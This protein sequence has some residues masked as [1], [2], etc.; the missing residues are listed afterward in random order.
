MNKLKIFLISLFSLIGYSN[1]I[2]QT[3]D[4][5]AGEVDFYVPGILANDAMQQVNFLLCFIENTNFQTFVDR[6]VYKA[7][8]DEAKCQSADGA[9]ANADQAAATGSSASTAGTGTAGNQVD[10][11]NYTPAVFQNVTEGNTLSGKG[12]VSLNFEFAEGAPPSAVTAYVKT[13]VSADASATNRF[14]T[15]LMR[16]DLRNDSQINLGGGANLP[17]NSEI[18]KGYLDVDNT[19]IKYRMQGFESPPRALD[20]DLADLNNIQ[21]ILQSTVRVSASGNLTTY[22][23]IHQINVNEGANRY[24]Q[25]FLSANQWSQVGTSWTEG[26]AITEAN[27]AAAISGADYVDTDGGIGATTTGQHCWDLRKSQAK[28]VVYE[29]GTY[30]ASNNNRLSLATPSMSLEANTTDNGGLSSPIWAFASYWGVHVN[31]NRRGDVTDSIQF[32]NQR[33][34]DD[35]AIYN[36]RKNYYEITKRERQYLSLNQLGGVSFQM[37]V[38]WQKNDATWGPKMGNLNF[39]NTGACNAAQGNCPEYSGTITVEG[40]TVTFTVTHGMNW[41]AGITP[42]E[43]NNSFSFTAAMWHTQMTN[44]SGWTLDMDFWDPDAHQSYSIP[45]AAFDAVASTNP[46]SQVRTRIESKI[47]LADLETDI[48]NGGAGATGLMCITRCL[49]VTNMNTS[50]AAAFTALGNGTSPSNALTTPFKDVGPWFKVATYYDSNN[51]NSVDNGETLYA[52]GSYNNIGGIRDNEAATYTVITEGGVKKLRDVGRNAVLEYSNANDTAL[53][54]RRHGDGLGNYRYKEKVS[55]YTVDNYEQNFGWAFN[56]QVVIDSNANKTA[57][58]CENESGEARGYNARYK[59][60]SGNAAQH[61]NAASGRTYYCESKLW[62]GAVATTYSIAIKQMPDYRLY[63]D[64]TSQFVN[65]SAPETVV[66]TVDANNVV[67]NFPNTNLAGKKYKLKFE[68][69]GELHNFP[70]RV[71]NTCTGTVVGRYV[72]NW[73]QCYRYV[74]EF[75]IKDGTVLAHTNNSRPDIKVRALRGDEYLLKLNPTPSGI[76]YTKQPSDLPAA[77]V[78]QTIFGTGT[79]GIGTVPTITIPSN[80]SNEAAVVHGVTVHSP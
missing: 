30:N 58:L 6:G 57:L 70:G 18:E 33:D 75:T 29:Y 43:L 72:N 71:V 5:D 28:R 1:L 44:G 74:H 45:Y 50:L 37:W 31:P 39:P 11:A 48:A 59:A 47:S 10:Q 46:A 16:Y 8:I 60:Q 77:S 53:S 80:G 22:S 40:S 51:N 41:S 12:W 56:M 13:T 34:K 64:T 66:L 67:Y 78:L 38:D 32:R 68:G 19:S 54:S 17:A 42:F 79:N 55:S 20:A 15:F 7:L 26:N 24:C 63:N 62:S 49:D 76:S 73:N 35:A 61:S 65:V 9:D 25:K 3:Y 2:A 14:G 69:F 27:L 4:Q 36:L 23:V 52:P 21:G